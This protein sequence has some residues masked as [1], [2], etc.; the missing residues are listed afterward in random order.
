MKYEVTQGEY[1]MFLNNL[2]RS[3]QSA[4]VGSAITGDTITNY[5]VMSNGT[6]LT[7]RNTITAPESGNGT[8]VPV[9]FSTT[10][11]TRACNY[12]TWMDGAAFAD[13]TALRPLSDLEFEKLA[14]G[15]GNVSVPLEWAWGTTSSTIAGALSG[16]EDGTETVTTANANVNFNT[17]G[18][19]CRDS[20][21]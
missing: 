10:R 5:Y 2:T 15:A 9:V 8:T 18:F 11:P 3:Q 21:V 17:S 7:A 16:T 14:R 4:R 12:L 20:H 1:V 13:W 6:T 19:S